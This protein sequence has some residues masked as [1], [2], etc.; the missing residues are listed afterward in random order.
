MNE[1]EET[2]AVAAAPPATDPPADLIPPPRKP[3]D[4]KTG[5]RTAWDMVNAGQTFEV[6]SDWLARNYPQHFANA[7]DAGNA[8]Q[9]EKDYC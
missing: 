3:H 1:N 7:T 8:M 9:S 2:G 6:A 4:C 5:I